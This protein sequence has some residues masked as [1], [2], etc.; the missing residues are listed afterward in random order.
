MKL[1]IAILNGE[2]V[3]R[4]STEEAIRLASLVNTID[5]EEGRR[6]KNF[7]TVHAD[8]RT[9]YHLLD[10]VLP[11]LQVIP[12]VRDGA[13]WCDDFDMDLYRVLPEAREVLAP[14]AATSLYT[15]SHTTYGKINCPAAW[16]TGRGG[17][18]CYFG[19]LAD[20]AG[21]P[22]WASLPTVGP[23]PSGY[24]ARDSVVE[25]TFEEVVRDLW[26][27]QQEFHVLVGKGQYHRI[28]MPKPSC[29]DT[30]MAAIRGWDKPPTPIREIQAARERVV[31][32]L[33]CAVDGIRAAVAQAKGA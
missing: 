16:D 6:L 31:L 30:L 17:N 10:R 1:R 32:D 9:K 4:L 26:V 8:Q 27:H 2:F 29:F 22:T 28:P 25:C 21:L 24:T 19:L 5:T 14:V 20:G 12:P 13:M 11:E 7:V 33:R 23:Q 18:A 15:C 3:L